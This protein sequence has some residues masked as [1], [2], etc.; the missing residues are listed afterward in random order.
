[1]LSV[2]R[3]VPMIVWTL[4][5]Q[6][7]DPEVSTLT[8]LNNLQ[9]SLVVPN[10]GRYFN[11]QPTYDLSQRPDAP[12]R[13]TARLEKTQ[14]QLQR[15]SSKLSRV[16]SEEEAKRMGIIRGQSNTASIFGAPLRNTHSIAS[17]M[18]ES[19]YAVLPHGVVLE[20]WTDEDKEELNDYVRHLLHSRR[21]KFKRSMRGFGK[22]VR[23]RKSAWP[24]ELFK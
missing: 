13:Q 22:Y 24:G 21:A 3:A 9:N 17:V 1:M 7:S 2:G 8:T 12:R 5:S 6:K 20:G 23:T 19:N 4:C 14:S 10:L 11:R 15:Q 16:P 18:S